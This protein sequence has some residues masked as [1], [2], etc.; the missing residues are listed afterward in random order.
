MFRKKFKHLIVIYKIHKQ[1][2]AYRGLEILVTTMALNQY[3][4]YMDRQN[5]NLDQW[6]TFHQQVQTLLIIKETLNRE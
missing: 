6:Q 2:K 5:I 3:L 4:A 1:K